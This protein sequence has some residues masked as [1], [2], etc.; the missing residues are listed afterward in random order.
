MAAI[1]YFAFGSNLPLARLRA[2]APSARVVD[3]AR[4][5]GFALTLDKRSLDGSGK[6]N[7]ARDASA[8]VWG[9]V[10]ELAEPE[11]AGLDGFEP[12][13]AR[14]AVP[15]TLRGGG[16]REAQTYLCEQREDGLCAAPAYLALILAG[17]REHQLPADWIERLERL[18]VRSA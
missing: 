3:A 10:F 8:H 5:A 6:V 14:I 11:L 15:V 12:G 1:A 17:A 4:L 16:A 13:Y 18:P 7:L 2:R 9:V